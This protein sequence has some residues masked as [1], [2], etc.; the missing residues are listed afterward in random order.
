VVRKG[1][2]TTPTPPVSKVKLKGVLPGTGN[3]YRPKL[4]EFEI[5]GKFYKY[6][7]YEQYFYCVIDPVKLIMHVKFPHSDTVI[8]NESKIIPSVRFH[9]G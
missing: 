2:L 3:L 7:V 8:L 6:P 1:A 9:T 4:A 5:Q